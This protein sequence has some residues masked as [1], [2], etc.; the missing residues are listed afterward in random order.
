MIVKYN[1]IVCLIEEF[2]DI[3][4]LSIDEL[5]GFYW[6][7]RKK[8]SARQGLSSIEECNNVFERNR[9]GKNQMERKKLT[10]QEGEMQSWRFSK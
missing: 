3:D 4:T 10:P 5:Q 6:F 2:K 8:N 1:Y 9:S 7:I